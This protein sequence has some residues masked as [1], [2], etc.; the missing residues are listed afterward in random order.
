MMISVSSIVNINRT[1]NQLQTQNLRVFPYLK[2]LLIHWRNSHKF[3]ITGQAIY[4]LT[5]TRP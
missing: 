3:T 2:Y 5:G 4:H 1:D